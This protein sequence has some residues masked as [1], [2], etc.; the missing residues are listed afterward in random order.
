VGFER[1]ATTTAASVLRLCMRDLESVSAGS[2]GT[3]L[4]A[5]PLG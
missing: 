1:E 4:L 5:N 2:H 3:L